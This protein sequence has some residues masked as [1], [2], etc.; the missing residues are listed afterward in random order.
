M[1][2][3]VCFEDM[4]VEAENEEEAKDKAVEEVRNGNLQFENVEPF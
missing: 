1:K 2:W 3:I 4:E